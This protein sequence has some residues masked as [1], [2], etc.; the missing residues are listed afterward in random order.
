M[1]INPDPMSYP[2]PETI[3]VEALSERDKD[4]LARTKSIVN[5]FFQGDQEKADSWMFL[6]NP[7]FGNVSPNF[8]FSI[9][10]GEEVFRY[11]ETA[12]Q[13]FADGEKSADHS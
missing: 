6:R 8:L 2:T 5:D 4:F 3:D 13:V 10:R 11:A 9:G 7:L 12:T 1:I